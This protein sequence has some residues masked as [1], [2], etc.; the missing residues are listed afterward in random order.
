M[1]S[2]SSDN[3]FL[4]DWMVHASLATTPYGDTDLDIL[5]LRLISM[6]HVSQATC[7]Q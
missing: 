4:E 1:S 5:D 6:A 2:K 3:G 7:G